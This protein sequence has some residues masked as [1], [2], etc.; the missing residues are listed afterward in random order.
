MTLIKN[1]I[2]LTV[3]NHVAHVELSRADKMNALDGDMFEA[4]A[5]AAANIAED[6]RVRVVVMSGAG[7]AFCAGLDMQ[8][9]ADMLN[10]DSGISQ[11]LPAKLAP[12]TKGI[13]NDVQ[14]AVWAWRELAV[15]VIA[16][17]H[18]VAV[19]GGL[20]IALAADMRY[21]A[22]NTKFSILELKWGLIPDMSSTQLMRHHMP[23]D[24]V[25]ELTYTAR[26]FETSEAEAY[27]VVTKVVDDPLQHAM[28][29]AR[30]I[31]NRNPTAIRASK[32]VLNAA[33]YVS[34]EEGLL[35]ESVEQDNII[36][37]ANQLEAVMAEL[38][39][40]APNF[41]D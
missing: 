28:D 34:A 11:S 27:H 36:G 24:I 18:G 20:Q 40:R 35:M 2:K 5:E 37:S 16:A 19:G 10:A 33:N 6:S 9:F 12:R 39:N 4:L 30:Q 22:P 15:P 38:Q 17:I 13:A 26:I 32:R 23:E 8:N 41:T 3:D 7:K 1:R 31:A 29:I 14:H 21:A 25:R